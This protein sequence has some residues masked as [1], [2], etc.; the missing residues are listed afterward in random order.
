MPFSFFF[1]ASFIYAVTRCGSGSILSALRAIVSPVSRSRSGPAS[2]CPSRRARTDRSLSIGRP[3]R[4]CFSV[5]P[6][7]TDGP[8]NMSQARPKP[9]SSVRH[10]GDEE[11]GFAMEKEVLREQYWRCGVSSR[12]T[13]GKESNPNNGTKV[14]RRRIPPRRAL[15]AETRAPDPSRSDVRNKRVR[16]FRLLWNGELPWL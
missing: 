12:T 6:S 7:R 10:E 13:R 8:A 16:F 5:S 2:D 3:T 9:L 11:R 4:S 15:G 1:V 14:S